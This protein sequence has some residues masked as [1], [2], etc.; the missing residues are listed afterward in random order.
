MAKHEVGD[1]RVEDVQTVTILAQH[2]HP[3]GGQQAVQRRACVT[4][5]AKRDER[6]QEQHDE[7]WA[8][9]EQGR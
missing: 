6:R 4:R 8:G 2:S 3:P 9:G 5:E 1:E 7:R